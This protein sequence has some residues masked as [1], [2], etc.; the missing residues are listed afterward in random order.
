MVHTSIAPFAG[1]RAD[2]APDDGQLTTPSKLE[3]VRVLD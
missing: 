1:Q 3:V 2:V